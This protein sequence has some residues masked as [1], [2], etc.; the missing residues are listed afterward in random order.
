MYRA[1][2]LNPNDRDLHRFLWREEPNAPLVDYRMTRVTF[3][4]SSSPFLAIKT[5]RQLALDFGTQ[6]PSAVPLV[7]NSFYVDDLLT[8]SETPEQALNLFQ[9]MRELLSKGGF[10]L[11]KW[12]SSSQVVLASIDPSLQETLPIQDLIDHVPSKYPKALGVEWDSALDTMSTQLARL[13]PI[14]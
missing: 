9:S 7:L 13:L 12:R 11:R 8:G 3:G 6:F 10:D 4:V 1:V 2:H 5:L 14:Y